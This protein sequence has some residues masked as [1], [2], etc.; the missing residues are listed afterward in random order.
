[1]D[2]VDDDA[3]YQSVLHAL[4]YLY[5]GN[6]WDSNNWWQSWAINSDSTGTHHNS[7]DLK[8]IGQILYDLSPFLQLVANQQG[9]HIITT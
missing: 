3:E 5:I 1:M 6:K 9:G 2:M 4:A 8:T 7:L